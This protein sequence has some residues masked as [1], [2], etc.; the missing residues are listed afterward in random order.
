MVH[1]HARLII[2]PGGG[3]EGRPGVPADAHVAE[4]RHEQVLRD[5]D[6]V[7]AAVG[8]DEAGGVVVG[9]DHAVVLPDMVQ[10]QSGGVVGVRVLEVDVVVAG[11]HV[12]GL[13]HV[14]E[15]LIL[16]AVVAAVHV[17]VHQ[18]DAAP[19]V[20]MEI[21]DQLLDGGAAA[22]HGAGNILPVA[23]GHGADED[24]AQA[25][26]AGG[27]QHRAHPALAGAHHDHRPFAGGDL[28][29]VVDERQAHLVA[30]G[31]LLQA[32]E[33]V[34]EPY[35]RDVVVLHDDADHRRVGFFMTH[36][37]IIQQPRQKMNQK[38]ENVFVL[39]RPPGQF[40]ITI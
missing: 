6:A 12:Q 4:A 23:A 30:P 3:G 25:V 15:G 34:G 19:V 1:L 26:P 16:G 28:L 11:G 35:G 31:G 22:V 38:N 21:P 33:A 36:T 24:R 27:V 37:V 9:A 18:G 14:Q 10:K 20:V 29:D 17:D 2:G 13:Y 39:C 7:F 8:E 40:I 32:L 5:A